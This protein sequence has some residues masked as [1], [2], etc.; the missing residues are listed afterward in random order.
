MLIA[1]INSATGRWRDNI[2]GHVREAPRGQQIKQMKIKTKFTKSFLYAIML[3]SC[4]FAMLVLYFYQS[5]VDASTLGVLFVAPL[6]GM[7]ALGSCLKSVKVSENDAE[8]EF[9]LGRSIRTPISMLK[10]PEFGVINARGRKIWIFIFSNNDS[11]L[12]ELHMEKS[13]IQSALWAK[14]NKQIARQ[15]DLLVVI[16]FATGLFI[17]G[18]GIGSLKTN[19][20]FVSPLIIILAVAVAILN[21]LAIWL[22][23]KKRL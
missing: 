4:I 15:N 7:L 18:A 20:Y 16:S 21:S 11:I 12:N 13:R 23:A 19:G 14:T 8:F 10:Y 17:N 22:T 6:L 3:C 1:P 5:R 9:Y 2:N